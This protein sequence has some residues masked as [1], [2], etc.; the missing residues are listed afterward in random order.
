MTNK[1]TNVLGIA[2]LVALIVLLLLLRGEMEY[3]KNLE[4]E[5]I[6]MRLSAAE[7]RLEYLF[8]EEFS[9]LILANKKHK[10]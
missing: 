7:L 6:K 5:T 4:M 9:Y 8:P 2:V 3:Q 10:E 1:M